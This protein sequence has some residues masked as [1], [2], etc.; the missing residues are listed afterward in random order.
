MSTLC[1]LFVAIAGVAA[2]VLSRLWRI[3]HSGVTPENTNALKIDPA[4]LAHIERSSKEEVFDEVLLVRDF[5]HLFW[6][7]SVRTRTWDRET[8]QASFSFYAKAAAYKF[9]GRQ[10]WGTNT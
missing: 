8:A 6:D 1:I 3:W 4:D 10:F 2:F 9:R 5:V 7:M